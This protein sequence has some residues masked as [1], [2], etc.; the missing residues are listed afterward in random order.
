MAKDNRVLILFSG[1]SDS[2]LLLLLAKQMKKE[3][4]ALLINYGQLHIAELDL[5]KK[6]LI[7]NKIPYSEVAISGLS[8]NSG[9]T[10]S[11]TQNL[12]EG[13]HSHWVPGRNTMF[14]AVALSEA[15]CRGITEI[16]YGPDF[17]DRVGLFPDCYQ[18]YVVKIDELFKSAGSYPIN[19]RAPLMGLTK[20]MVLELL[21]SYGINKDEIYS[22]YGEHS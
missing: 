16:W 10:G 2:L 7:E 1:G 20:E 21:D 6:Y 4:C 18:E 19:V 14:L 12:Y 9:L 5:A 11:G 3:A 17:S 15:E 8:A 13:V 22:G